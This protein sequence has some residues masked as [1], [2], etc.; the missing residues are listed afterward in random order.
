VLFFFPLLLYAVLKSRSPKQAIIA[1]MIGTLL[2]VLWIIVS[3]IYYGDILPT[4]FYVKT[5]TMNLK[6]AL[7]NC[8]YILFY[9]FF[10]G[11][12][13]V[14][15]YLYTL[16]PQ[17][18]YKSFLDSIHQNIKKMWW[19][20]L[21]IFFEILYGLTMATKHMMFSFRYFVPYIP[22][23]VL[24]VLELIRDVVQTNQVTFHSRI[25]SK[26]LF[27]GL[28]VFLLCFQCLQTIYTYN[29]SLNGISFMGEYRKMNVQR[30]INFTNILRKHSE[31]IKTHWDSVKK[32]KNRLPRIYVYAGGTLP[33]TFKD[34]YIYEKLI[35]YRH[36][37]PGWKYV[38]PD[39]KLSADYICMIAPKH[40]TPQSKLPLPL[41]NYT[42][43]SSYKS[44]LVYLVYLVYYNPNP[45]KHTLPSTIKGFS[46]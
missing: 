13:P 28:L 8:L 29:H 19:L 15:F 30:Y 1:S 10:I 43:I 9:L 21:A 45:Q 31:D 7:E 37:M 44:F 6:T 32:D 39:V 12:I 17:P 46:K 41:K 26:L 14:L 2:P 22:S 5:P 4:S 38:K 11:I 33:Y 16:L 3:I 36:N 20:Y 27:S 18:K 24:L 40:G 35:S 42:L 25:T 34:S 23:T